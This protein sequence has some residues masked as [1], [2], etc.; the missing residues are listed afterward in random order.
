MLADP[1]GIVF[2]LLLSSH[3]PRRDRANC[4]APLRVGGGEIAAACRDA[5][6]RVSFL[7]VLCEDEDVLWI[8]VENLLDL[9]RRDTVTGQVPDILFVPV[10]F[11]NT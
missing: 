6:G 4:L 3:I 8:A 5:K 9:L 11:V 10:E 1:F 2:L 7:A